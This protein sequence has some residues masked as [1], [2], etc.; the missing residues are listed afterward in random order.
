MLTNFNNSWYRNAAE[1]IC[2]KLLYSFHSIV[3]QKIIWYCKE[4]LVLLGILFNVRTAKFVLHLGI[5]LLTCGHVT[6]F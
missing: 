3:T 1:Y 5:W 2:S 4:Q 6:R